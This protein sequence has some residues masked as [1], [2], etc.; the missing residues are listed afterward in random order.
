MKNVTVKKAGLLLQL[1]ENEATHKRDFE[2]AWDAFQERAIK[3]FEQKLGALRNAKR[4]QQ[5]ELWV[6]LEIPEDHSDDYERAIEMLQWEVSDEVVLTEQEF[7]QFVQDK[8]TWKD[9]F[10]MSNIAYTG[11][12]S[13]S[14][15]L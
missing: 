7:R 1:R 9:K 15:A 13:P 10:T 14:K 12:A 2:I 8:W 3:N 6:N 5:I 11:S 4:G